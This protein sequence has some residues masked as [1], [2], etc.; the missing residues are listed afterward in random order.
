MAFQRGNLCFVMLAAF[1]LSACTASS[2][3]P[4]KLSGSVQTPPLPQVTASSS[5]TVEAASTSAPILVV[6]AES[7]KASNA[8]TPTS[9]PN[10]SP[11]AVPSAA[12]SSQDI[13]AG[14]RATAQQFFD[15]LNTAFATGDVSKITAL[16]APAC[17]C[18][19][20]VKMIADTYGQ[21]EHIVGVS[22]TMTK[23]TIATLLP[24]GAT[25]DLRYAISGGHIL[26]V[27]GKQINTSVAN[28]DEH[29]AM[30]IINAGGQWTVQQN[31]LLN[32]PTK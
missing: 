3:H 12:L 21:H 18:R 28:P 7:T 9:P 10:S 22:A 5:A 2:S 29:S 32:S 25:L 26:D 6:P 23:L 17:G 16:T 1:S 8:G 4:S 27:A 19:N 20:L 31:T 15:D 13:E 14:V 30:V 24:S 11:I